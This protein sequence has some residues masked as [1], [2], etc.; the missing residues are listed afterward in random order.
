MQ[1]NKARVMKGDDSQAMCALIAA[2]KAVGLIINGC[3]CLVRFRLK[4]I[5]KCTVKHLEHIEYIYT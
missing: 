2:G 5:A 4:S 3:L 1:A